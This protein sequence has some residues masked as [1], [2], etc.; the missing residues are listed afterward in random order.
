MAKTVKSGLIAFLVMALAV[1]ITAGSLSAAK[2][3]TVSYFMPQWKTL[4]FDNAKTAES[5]GK[6]LKS[7]GCEVEV[8][9]HN[10]HTDVKYRQTKWT[11]LSFKSDDEAHKWQH[12]LKKMGFQTKH[13][14]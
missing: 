10:G 6:T 1:T 12:W 11:V 14:H 2:K 4:H 13:T 7:L 5:R 9:A 8:K 3:W